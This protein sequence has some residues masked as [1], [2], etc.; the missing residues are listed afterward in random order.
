MRNFYPIV[1]TALLFVFSAAGIF[2]EDG[3]KPE[4]DDIEPNF[5]FPGTIVEIKGYNFEKELDK[6]I[7][8]FGDLKTLPDSAY[9]DEGKEV[10]R[11]IVPEGVKTCEMKLISGSTE[12]P[13]EEEFYVY[14]TELTNN[15]IVF[16]ILG[17]AFVVFLTGFSL[18]KV[19]GSKRKLT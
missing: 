5:G 11:V 19:L 14:D 13:Y 8:Y 16:M 2:A 3:N 15:G 17:F 12:I 7:F 1:L 9:T 6:N 10:L 18:F 4:I